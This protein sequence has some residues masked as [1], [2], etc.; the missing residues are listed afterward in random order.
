MSI[1]LPARLA[2]RTVK[3]TQTTCYLE[4]ILFK[5]AWQ[6]NNSKRVQKNTKWKN[7]ETKQSKQKET[8]NSNIIAIYNLHRSAIPTPNKH[9]HLNISKNQFLRC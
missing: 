1:R 3:H 8:K 5:E 7:T 2:K 6:R 4:N 9:Y